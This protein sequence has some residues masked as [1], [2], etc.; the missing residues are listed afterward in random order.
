MAKRVYFAFHYQDVIDFRAN[1]V[2]NHNALQGSQ[3]AGYFDASIWEESEKKGDL[4]LKRMINS[5]LQNT[6]VT[7]IL[8]GSET[9]AR[10]WVQYEI[11]KSIERGNKVIGVHINKIPC[12]N[13]KTKGLGPNPFDYLGLM[14][15]EAGTKGTPTIWNGSKWDY[16]QDLGKFEISKQPPTNC[17]KHLQL[18]HWLPNF[19]WIGNDGFNNFSS[20]VA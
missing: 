3:K 19:D 4:A 6:S 5:E 10:R 16:Y 1:V 14:I 17:G 20:W 12:K 18:S 7:A 2:R 8:I 13:K 15:D 9:Y 11:M